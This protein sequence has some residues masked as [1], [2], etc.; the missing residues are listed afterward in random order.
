[1]PDPAYR[2]TTAPRG[3]SASTR[4]P[5]FEIHPPRRRADRV[6]YYPGCSLD[7]LAAEYDASTRAVCRA[8]SIELVEIPDWSC[9]GSTP[10]HSCDPLLSGALAGRNLALAEGMGLD[11]VMTLSLIHI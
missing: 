8:L 5:K 6:A 7:G 4:T 3:G 2:V 9:C 1:M 10:A 11:V